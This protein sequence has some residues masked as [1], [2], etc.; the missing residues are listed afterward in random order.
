MEDDPYYQQSYA[1]VRE[2]TKATGHSVR[3]VYLYTAM[4][5]LASEINDPS[6]FH[7]CQRLWD[8][9]ARQM[10]VT[11]GIG[12]TGIGEAFTTDYHLPND[13]AYAETC[14][15]IGL[16]FFASRMLELDMDGRYGDVME[17][18]FYNTVLA[19]MQLD[20]KRFFYVNPLE[21]LPGISGVVATHLHDKPLR[22]SWYACAYCPPNIA[23]LI[24]SIGK[25]A[26]SS[27]QTTNYCLL[28]ADGDIQF[29]NQNLI[30]CQTGYPYDFTVRYQIISTN[31]TLAIR[32][33]SWS[34]NYEILVNDQRITPDLQKGY[35]YIHDLK[36][37]DQVTLRLDENP[38]FLYASPKIA[39]DTGC[40]ALQ[41]GPLIYCFEGVDNQGDVLS[42]RIDDSAPILSC[43][44]DPALLGGTEMLKVSAHRVSDCNSLYTLQKPEET[45]CSAYAVPYYTWGNRGENQMRVWMPRI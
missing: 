13:T 22:P 16:I 32:I 26:Y 34:L 39:N 33:P 24:T 43:G 27:N 10:Y 38:H 29:D 40:V 1:P 41:H 6:L 21:V 19:G 42:L 37:G 36:A 20:G 18:A 9:I 35:A 25:Y 12:S 28:Y 31:R 23:R 5:D 45:A 7:A 14:A 11:G 2:Q 17:Q 30:R 15:S 4:A 8:S 3:A 44:Y